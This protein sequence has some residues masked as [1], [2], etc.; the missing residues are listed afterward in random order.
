MMVALESTKLFC[1][2]SP[3]EIQSLLKVVQ[4]Q[5]FPVGKT[6]FKEGD[7]GDGLYI[8]RSG[9]VQIS[10]VVSDG[11][12]RILSR[13]GPGEFFGEMAVV[14]NEPRSATVMTDQETIVYFV[15]REEMLRVL[16]SSP[17]LAVNLVREFSMRLREFNRQFIHEVLQAERLT[18]VGRFT[19]SIVHD[20][21][22]PLNVIGLA[23]DLAGMDNASADM[24]R[25]AR[26]RIRKQVERLSNMINELLDFT[27]GSQAAVIL[28]ETDF[29][30]LVE[31]VVD[32]LRQQLDQNS[33]TVECEN[34][35]PDITI[36]CD[37][38]RLMHLFSNLAHNAVDAMPNGGKIILRFILNEKEV[39]TEVED[40]G[41]GVPAEVL[42]R[43]FE[44]FMTHGKIQGTGLGL[45]ICKRIIEDH[46]GR[47]AARSEPNRGAVFSFTL[48]FQRRR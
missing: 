19:R 38:A 13:L 14:D 33:V 29:A 26:S 3:A 4:I 27:R 8:V 41:T 25:V 5:T 44:P 30:E 10:A 12:R 31:H 23:A 37:P 15:P 18:L 35:P 21:K 16:E 43:L 36:L 32:D 17:K 40:T 34:Q 6:I 1:G 2:L 42:P 48:P 45:S 39:V 47:I 24:R 46:R 28:A 22:N 9:L 20:F 7:A 11:D